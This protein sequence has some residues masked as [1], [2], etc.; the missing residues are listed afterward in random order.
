MLKKQHTKNFIIFVCETCNLEC[1][2][3]SNFAQHLSTHKHFVKENAK[4]VNKENAT[5][6]PSVNCVYCNKEYKTRVGLWYH[7]K[8]CNSHTDIIQNTNSIDT[9]IHDNKNFKKLILEVVKSNTELHKQ[10]NE[11]HKQMAEI[12]KN[13]SITHN[14]NINNHSNNKTFNLQFFLNEQCKDAMNISD[15]ANSFE[16]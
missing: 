10:N 14:N 1:S 2:K 6:A 9:L 5:P 13:T 7:N 4:V 11:L 16:L 12:C 15:F 3:K 8:K